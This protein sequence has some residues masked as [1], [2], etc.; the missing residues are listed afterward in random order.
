MIPKPRIRNSTG[1]ILGKRPMKNRDVTTTLIK[2]ISPPIVGV[3][4]FFR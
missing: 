4:A 3:P 1:I 2:M